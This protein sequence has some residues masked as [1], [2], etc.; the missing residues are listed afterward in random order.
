MKNIRYIIFIIISCLFV[1]SCQTN[2][3]IKLLY[4]DYKIINYSEEIYNNT[5]RKKLEVEIINSKKIIQ[6]KNSNNP[7]IYIE[8]N[9]KINIAKGSLIYRSTPPF[10]FDYF[11]LDIRLE[12]LKNFDKAFNL[13]KTLIY[14]NKDFDEYVEDIV[15]S[16]IVHTREGLFPRISSNEETN[17]RTESYEKRIFTIEYY[18]DYFI[19]INFFR[20]FSSSEMANE[21]YGIKYYIID[22]T[23]KRKLTINDLINYIPNDLLKQIIELNYDISEKYLRGNIFP[24]DSI[25][26][27]N[28]NIELIWNI[29][30]ILPYE[31]GIV[32]IEIQDEIIQQYLTEKGK[33]I[34]M[35]IDKNKY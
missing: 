14:D 27:C 32:K 1:Y 12:N 9:N 2:K 21:Y 7:I 22:L 8:Y 25:N 11:F 20:S 35:L 24:P 10:N 4:N 18:S 34:K 17:Y 3:I 23:E 19:I 16:A 33:M 30:Q 13:I 5:L 6:L 31:N 28:D 15:K 29:K 26:F